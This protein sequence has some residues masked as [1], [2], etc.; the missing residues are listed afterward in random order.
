MS[1]HAASAVL[2]MG[3]LAGTARGQVLRPSGWAPPPALDFALVARTLQSDIDWRRREN[4]ALQLGNSGDQRWVGPLATAAAG[5]PSLRVRRAARDALANIR[6]ANRPPGFN[7]PPLRPGPGWGGGGL[8]SDPYVDMVEAWYLQF[9]R[10]SPDAA[11]LAAHVA[12]LQ[13]GAD[14]GDVQAA[15]IGSDEYW[16]RQGSTARG[17]VRG[18]YI[19]VLGRPAG[20]SEVA[21]WLNR[22][23]VN[24]GDRTQVAREFLGA[25]VTELSLRR[26]F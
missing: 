17:F 9:L 3:A 12:I 26:P 14:P 4:A 6:L 24:R 22:F 15:I 5:D 21:S 13:S 16:R 1:R 8:P 7:V 2:L 25:A 19:D 20:P 11:G 10:R 23:N 18:L